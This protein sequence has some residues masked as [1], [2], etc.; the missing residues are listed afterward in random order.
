MSTGRG[1]ASLACGM[2]EIDPV[3]PFM[4]G[5][6]R[7]DYTENCALAERKLCARCTPFGQ[8]LQFSR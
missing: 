8:E 4:V 3:L 2:A 6:G 7:T 1:R 5:P